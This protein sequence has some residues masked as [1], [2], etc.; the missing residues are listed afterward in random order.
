MPFATAPNPIK[1]RAI[2]ARMT[3]AFRI[4]GRPVT[5]GAIEQAACW[6]SGWVNIEAGFRAQSVVAD[7][8]YEITEVV[9]AYSACLRMIA[10]AAE[11]EAVAAL[12]GAAEQAR[13][14]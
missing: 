5:D 6:M 11:D 14:A 8:P 12:V 13:A 9:S 3:D 4:C 2:A 7:V 10:A 1:A